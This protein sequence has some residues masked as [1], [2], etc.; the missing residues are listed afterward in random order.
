MISK[1]GPVFVPTPLAHNILSPTYPH[2][3]KKALVDAF[4]NVDL[5]KKIFEDFRGKELPP[6]FGMKNALKLQYGV[7]PNRVDDAYRSLMESA[8]TAGFFATKSGVRTHLI[9]PLMQP[10]PRTGV[11]PS[12]DEK[13][14]DE[15]GGSGNG[16]QPPKP[17]QSDIGD[18]KAKYLS[19]LIKLFEDKAEKGDLDEKLMERIERLIGAPAA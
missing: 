15:F 19:A 14:K 3:A 18:A 12:P 7:A 9:L 17:P 5:F 16:G 6:E 11:T 4:L 2:D 1:T 8:D 13:N 10:I